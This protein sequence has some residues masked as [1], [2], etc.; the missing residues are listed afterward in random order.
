MAMDYLTLSHVVKSMRNAASL[1]LN[2]TARG[3][4]RTSTL[5]F[6]VLLVSYDR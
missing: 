1:R 5:D 2:R 3:V 6:V 4:C